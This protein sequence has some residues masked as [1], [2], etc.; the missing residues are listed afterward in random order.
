MKRTFRLRCIAGLVL[1]A[2]VAC[3]FAQTID[4]PRPTP[5]QPDPY[6]QQY[7]PFDTSHLKDRPYTLNLP[8]PAFPSSERVQREFVVEYIYD[9]AYS[10]Y[11][12][13][14]TLPVV[15]KDLAK[16]ATP[17]DALIAFYS[18]MRAGDFNAWLACWDDTSQKRFTEEAKTLKHD[19][20]FW[21]K[22]FSDAFSTRKTTVLVDR[23]ETQMY[24]ILD[25]QL[26]GPTPLRVPTVFKLVDGEWKAT[27]DLANNAILSR[28]Q[29]GMA[30]ALNLVPP[31][32]IAQLDQDNR[33]QIEAQQ[34]FVDQH[35]LRDRV[36]QA[37]Q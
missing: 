4:V 6:Q 31:M 37:G 26:S 11:S 12:P 32:P 15:A 21:K 7:K 14:V 34:Q 17:E 24:V 35:T 30:G 19:E 20:A 23:I 28:M 29:P 18:A 9:Y 13:Q 25:T 3:L 10:T 5:A 27:N 16:R 33:Q 2:P 8:K 22:Y 36:V 1:V